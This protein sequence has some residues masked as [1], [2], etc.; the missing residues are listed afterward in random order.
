MPVSIIVNSRSHYVRVVSSLTTKKSLR[1]G[2]IQNIFI[3]TAYF[4]NAP[5]VK[6]AELSTRIILAVFIINIVYKIFNYD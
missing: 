2:V 3:E 5:L 1:F 4:E 6:M